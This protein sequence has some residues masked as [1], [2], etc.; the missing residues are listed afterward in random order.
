MWLDVI[1][2]EILHEVVYHRKKRKADTYSNVL[3]SSI[4]ALCFHTNIAINIVVSST[5]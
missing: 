4:V 1:Y 5:L 2:I 3:I